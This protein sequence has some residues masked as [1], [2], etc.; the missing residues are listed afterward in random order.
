[1][2]FRGFMEMNKTG[3]PVIYDVT[4]SLQRP[5]ASGNISGGQPEYVKQMALAAIATGTLSGL[6]IETHPQ[7]KKAL[8]D[9]QSMLPME[10]TEDLLQAIKTMEETVKTIY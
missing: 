1:M 8:S 10:Q 3:Y 5:A 2:D 9:A 4:H 7:P 6:F